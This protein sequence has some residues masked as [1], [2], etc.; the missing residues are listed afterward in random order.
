M[1]KRIQVRN[2]H[3]V[4]LGERYVGTY[5]T[6]S[7]ARRMARKFNLAMFNISQPQG[8]VGF[9]LDEITRSM[10]ISS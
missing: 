3:F 2:R 10:E 1:K 5:P 8:W 6:E 4:V 9:R 7:I